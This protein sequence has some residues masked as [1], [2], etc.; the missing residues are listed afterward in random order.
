MK[1]AILIVLMFLFAMS[2]NAK[3]IW[4]KDLTDDR[5][6][7]F[8]NQ[9]WDGL[10]YTKYGNYCKYVTSNKDINEQIGDVVIEISGIY[11]ELTGGD[12]QVYNLIM[13]KISSNYSWNYIDNYLASCSWQ[14]ISDQAIRAKNSTLDFLKNNFKVD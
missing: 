7:K 6:S 5:F 4:I 14:Y 3:T 12:I 11:I 1:Q 8:Y 10:K 13:C 9:Y 2:L